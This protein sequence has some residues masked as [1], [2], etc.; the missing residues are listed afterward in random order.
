MVGGPGVGGLVGTS[1][2]SCGQWEPLTW[3]PREVGES[4]VAAWGPGEPPGPVG[5]SWSAGPGWLM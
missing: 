4:W 1:W 2:P 5:A 3:T